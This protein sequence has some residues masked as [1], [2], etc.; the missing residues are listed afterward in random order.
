MASI[1]SSPFCFFFFVC[2]FFF[3]W[4]SSRS[5][6]RPGSHGQGH[7]RDTAVS[8]TVGVLHA[9]LGGA[10]RLTPTLSHKK[11][12]KLYDAM[13]IYSPA[14][15]HGTPKPLGCRGKW[16]KPGPFSGSMGSFAGE[17]ESRCSRSVGD[18]DGRY[19]WAWLSLLFQRLPWHW[20]EVLLPSSVESTAHV[21]VPGWVH[22]SRE[23]DLFVHSA[24]I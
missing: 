1:L 10:N 4:C 16:S 11:R 18:M 6:K 5:Q 19:G 17:Y 12:S 24:S 9:V 8:L 14:D 7:S 20:T 2:S 23:F 3:G 22:E 15:Q 13:P 21:E